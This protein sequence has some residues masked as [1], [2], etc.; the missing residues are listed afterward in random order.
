MGVA[1]F[2]GRYS[3]TELARVELESE[4]LHVHVEFVVEH[5]LCTLDGGCDLPFDG[6]QRRARMARF[7][8]PS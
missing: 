5:E 6:V 1:I 4:G 8:F 7:C 3:G 2:E